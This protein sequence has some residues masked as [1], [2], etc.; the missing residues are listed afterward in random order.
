MSSLNDP[1]AH[2]NT[3]VVT[4]V[5]KCG[6]PVLTPH[7]PY[8]LDTC[9]HP[10]KV[11]ANAHEPKVKWC[12]RQLGRVGLPK[13]NFAVVSVAVSEPG[14]GA[15]QNS[16]SRPPPPATDGLALKL[17]KTSRYFLAPWS[18]SCHRTCGVKPNCGSRSPTKCKRVPQSAEIQASANAHIDSSTQ[19]SW[20]TKAGDM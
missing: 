4:N 11:L 3:T 16:A 8:C 18:R 6:V 10:P 5:C 15:Y 14:W 13:D 7:G 19:C 9:H 2:T 1:T 12:F 20:G 17:S